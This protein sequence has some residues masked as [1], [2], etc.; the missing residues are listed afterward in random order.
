[1]ASI[2][3]DVR[4]QLDSL[5]ATVTL[6]IPYCSA[7]MSLALCR[8]CNTI[9]L[10]ATQG[11]S[12]LKIHCRSIRQVWLT[13]QSMSKEHSARRLFEGRSPIVKSV[14]PN[15]VPGE[16]VRKRT[17]I[18]K[19]LVLSVALNEGFHTFNKQEKASISDRLGGRPLNAT[20]RCIQRF[21]SA[22]LRFVACSSPRP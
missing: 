2:S 20:R 22:A 7:K 13:T 8:S 12:F 10:G 6:T 19:S 4:L 16:G 17:S 11:R 1:M 9:L 15:F 21:D 5:P 18:C 14:F 3:Y